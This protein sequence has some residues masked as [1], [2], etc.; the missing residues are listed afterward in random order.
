M[1]AGTTNDTPTSVCCS[2]QL[3][4]LV[5]VGGTG[6][7]ASNHAWTSVDGVTWIN[8]SLPRNNWLSVCWSKEKT[9]FVAVGS[10]ATNYAASSSDGVTWN[11]RT[12]SAGTW[13]C[14][15]WVTEKA[16]F[17]A[18]SSTTVYEATSTDGIVWS[19][20][21][22]GAGNWNAI[23]WSPQLSIYVVVQFGVAVAI[24][25]DAANWSSTNAM[26][27]SNWLAIVWSPGLNRF[28]ATNGNFVVAHY[29]AMAI[30][31]IV[32]TNFAWQFASG[33]Y[34]IG[35]QGTSGSFYIGDIASAMTAI[36][37]AT[38]AAIDIFAGTAFSRAIF[39]FNVKKNA[40]N[41]LTGIGEVGNNQ[42]GTY[43]ATATYYGVAI[44]TATT[45]TF[46]NNVS[47]PGYSEATF[48]RSDTSTNIYYYQAPIM[49]HNPGQWYDSQQ[50]QTQTLCNGYGRL[51][52]FN[53]N[54]L[55]ST[56]SLRV[57]MINGQP[58]LL[59]ARR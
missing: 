5:A 15:I 29:A 14:V 40:A 12:L 46:S 43:A 4:L 21:S 22:L 52:D 34:L 47:G 17:V 6:D 8:R 10:G 11:T 51:S 32:G 38:W 44:A 37:D 48:I 35:N 9:T 56:C 20:G 2:P 57:V 30:N 31:P 45:A 33:K 55:G 23:A 50:S 19:N 25:S 28:V 24:S 49:G 1:P 18:V 3:S 54:T 58:S 16:I 13:N 26:D 41:L 7:V 27:N 39:T 36:T 42:A 59:S 53:G